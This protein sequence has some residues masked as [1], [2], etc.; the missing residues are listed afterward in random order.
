MML[1]LIIVLLVKMQLLRRNLVLI[2]S[3]FI[4]YFL[5]RFRR[6]GIRRLRMLIVLSFVSIC[7]WI[8]L[9]ICSGIGLSVEWNRSIGSEFDWEED[10]KLLLEEKLELT[11]LL[12]KELILSRLCAVKMAKVWLVFNDFITIC[13]KLILIKLRDLLLSLNSLRGLFLCVRRFLLILYWFWMMGLGGL[14]SIVGVCLRV[15]LLKRIK[16]KLMNC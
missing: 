16:G 12:L 4:S 14:R 2:I 3:L 7:W 1:L 9:R 11:L 15:M 5:L 6:L 13:W 8:S 10:R